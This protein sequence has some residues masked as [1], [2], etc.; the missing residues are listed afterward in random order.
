LKTE[1]LNTK[2]HFEE[3][4]S[5]GIETFK[6]HLD[7]YKDITNIYIQTNDDKQMGISVPYSVGEKDYICHPNEYLEV[8]YNDNTYA[9]T[10]HFMIKIHKN[11]E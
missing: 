4:F 10:E 1:A 5:D 2:T 9:N 3:K 11:N 7:V 8:F 6:K